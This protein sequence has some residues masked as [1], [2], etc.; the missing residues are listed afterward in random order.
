MFCVYR[1]TGSDKAT[2]DTTMESERILNQQLPV[3]WRPG[4]RVLSGIEMKSPFHTRNIH[5]TQT[6]LLPELGIVFIHEVAR[7]LAESDGPGLATGQQHR[8]GRLQQ[9]GAPASYAGP[10][11]HTTVRVIRYD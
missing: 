9:V 6:L 5:S 11:W 3:S 2:V 1:L 4:H 8:A 10:H 7:S